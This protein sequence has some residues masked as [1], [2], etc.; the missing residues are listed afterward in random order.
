MMTMTTTTIQ[1]KR[2]R[3][4]QPRKYPKRCYSDDV[5]DFA[6]VSFK[7]N[8]T[9]AQTAVRVNAKFNLGV[10]K[11]GVRGWYHAYFDPKKL[12]TAVQTPPQII[13]FALDLM[14]KG[15]HN[16]EINRQIKSKLHY[17][18]GDGSVGYWR[19]KYRPETITPFTS[20]HYHWTKEV[21]AY[22]MKLALDSEIMTPD[23]M[24]V[25]VNKHFP[26]AKMTGS[27]LRQF[28]TRLQPGFD[29]A[30]RRQKLLW[31]DRSC[32][33]C[34]SS[35]SFLMITPRDKPYPIW[36]YFRNKMYCFR[37]F[38]RIRHAAA[39]YQNLTDDDVANICKT[40]HYMRRTYGK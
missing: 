38:G 23:A 3:H 25:E 30:A 12:Y 37:C 6:I 21:I 14:D 31:K 13:K 24:A 20:R 17:P 11:L 29:W 26:G 19:A 36:R 28:V 35:D 22:A 7:E 39:R 2:V 34:G 27:G 15:V 40:N 5:I 10:T 16:A 4:A 32:D 8:Y 18:I 9:I 33:G 1:R